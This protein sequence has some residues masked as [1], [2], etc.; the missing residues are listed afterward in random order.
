MK[1]TLKSLIS[2]CLSVLLLISAVACA[3]PIEPSTG[4][5]STVGM[6]EEQTTVEITA[7]DLTSEESRTE[8]TELDEF[9]ALFPKALN[10]SNFDWSA[11]FTYV[12]ESPFWGLP[13]ESRYFEEVAPRVYIG[14]PVWEKWEE[15]LA[16]DDLILCEIYF[17]G[18]VES[19]YEGYSGAVT[20]D[21]FAE[22]DYLTTSLTWDEFVEI[23][24]EYCPILDAN[25]V[26]YCTDEN[27]LPSDNRHWVSPGQEKILYGPSV[28][29]L[30]TKEQI[31]NLQIPEGDLYI[32]ISAYHNYK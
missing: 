30:L 24:E 1:I 14:E 10:V 25:G 32:V 3:S 16:D 21:F 7:E 4:N 17:A 2:L 6:T 19:F 27:G 18:V 12:V 26:V 29:C 31:R 11:G 20:G 22:Y 23:F 15:H 9:T 13:K 8:T 5:D 28:A